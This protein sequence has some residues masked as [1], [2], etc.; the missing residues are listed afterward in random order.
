MTRLLLIVAFVA[1]VGIG[2]FYALDET[3]TTTAETDT[4]TETLS[5]D[6]AEAVDN[7]ATEIGEATAETEQAAESVA[8]EA[9]RNAEEIAAASER[10]AEQAAAEIENAATQ[11]EESAERVASETEQAAQNSLEAAEN[12][13]ERAAQQGRE[14][15]AETETALNDAA[16]EI[17]A[18]TNS[19]A[20]ILEND[21]SEPAAGAVE[22]ET[23]P[24]T[25]VQSDAVPATEDADGGALLQAFRQEDLLTVQGF[26]FDRM[27]NAV[28]RS[29]LADETKEEVM[30]VLRDIRENPG[31]FLDK[32]AELREILSN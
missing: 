22:N 8:A 17:A 32:S 16:D 23:Q 25:D 6:L 20:S 4:T 9:E 13:T 14:A 2:V 31:T 12:A 7:A 24:S 27:A 30:S 1:L 26:D 28:E 11:A 18:E 3:A 29:S 10:A 21:G 15:L 5:S 19:L